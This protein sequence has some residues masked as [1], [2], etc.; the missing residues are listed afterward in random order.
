MSQKKSYQGHKD[1]D[2]VFTEVKKKLVVDVR[3]SADAWCRLF[4]TALA[5]GFVKFAAGTWIRFPY[6]ATALV[7]TSTEYVFVC[8][9][10]AIS[11]CRARIS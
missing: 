8:A 10:M 4:A 5:P 2:L 1:D 7:S 11:C 6:G 9:E 3:D